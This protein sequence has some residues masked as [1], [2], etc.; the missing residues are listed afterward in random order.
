MRDLVRR[1]R[2]AIQVLLLLTLPAGCAS[3]SSLREREREAYRSGAR[4]AM[5]AVTQPPPIVFF[6]GWVRNNAIEWHPDLTLAQG[7]LEAE[8]SGRRTPSSIRIFSHEGDVIDIDPAT[9]L[10]GEDYYLEKGDRV[11]IQR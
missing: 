11:E 1:R 9:L 6:N 3:P 5:Q 10:D 4:D 8:Y 7:L 2:R